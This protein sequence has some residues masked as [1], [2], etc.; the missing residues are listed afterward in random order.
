MKLSIHVSRI[1]QTHELLGKLPFIRKPGQIR[2]HL[3]QVLS[4][5]IKFEF[6]PADRVREQS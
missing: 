6:S 5:L 3:F 2:S 1:T 4:M